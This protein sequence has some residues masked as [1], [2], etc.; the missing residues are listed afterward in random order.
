MKNY[1]PAVKEYVARLS[2]NDIEYLILRI[3]RNVG[4]DQAEVAG[5]FGKDCVINRHLQSAINYKEWFELVDEIVDL[6][7]NEIYY[8]FGKCP[9]GIKE[10]W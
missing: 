10:L 9:Y 4:S 7:R 8:R 2:D 1:S 3:R 5:M 6:L